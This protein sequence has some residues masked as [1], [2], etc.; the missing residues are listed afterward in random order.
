MW[1][2]V[3]LISQG[4]PT[5]HHALSCAW[6]DNG[7]PGLTTAEMSKSSGE[8]NIKR[9]RKLYG[10]QQWSQNANEWERRR[11]MK[12]DD[13]TQFKVIE[14]EFKSII[15]I[16]C[17]VVPDS[18][19]NSVPVLLYIVCRCWGGQHHC[20]HW[21][22]YCWRTCFGCYI[23]WQWNGDSFSDRRLSLIEGI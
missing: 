1:F 7:Q 14:Q 9:Y 5:L 4:V 15:S 11:M 22:I 2:V 20:L 13:I 18:S 6:L 17:L 19:C 16:M 23:R 21:D 10:W 3:R 8:T 12:I